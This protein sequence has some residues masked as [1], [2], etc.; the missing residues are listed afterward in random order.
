MKKHNISQEKT[1]PVQERINELVKEVEGIK[2]EE[3]KDIKK[4]IQKPWFFFKIYVK[5][6]QSIN[7][8]DQI[9]ED[10]KE[11]VLKVVK[12]LSLENDAASKVII[13]ELR[14]A[15]K[16]KRSY[17]LSLD[18]AKGSNVFKYLL[19]IKMSALAEYNAQT[20]LQ[21]LQSFRLSKI[22]SVIG[23]GLLII[24]IVLGIY[25]NLSGGSILDAAYL[26]SIA[27]ILTEFISGVFFY[28]YNRTLQQLN[29]FHDKMIA[30]Q[31]VATSLMVNSL[32]VDKMK[33]DECK[34]ELSKT[35]MSIAT[36]AKNHEAM[37]P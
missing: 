16:E 30:S 9:Y 33:R 32:I 29:L 7:K 1:A 23:F 19:L 2:S 25:S 20:R 28:L 17:I 35:L 11:K 8:V 15:Q 18:T 26:T 4:I 27:G 13:D 3:K 37:R 36:K 21:A 12:S 34:D 31:H 22:A 14:N 6:I 24:G 5:V 10:F